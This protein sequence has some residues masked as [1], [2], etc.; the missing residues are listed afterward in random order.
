ENGPGGDW[1]VLVDVT[2]AGGNVTLTAYWPSPSGRYVAY[3]TAEGGSE[4]TT[5]RVQD[6]MTGKTLPDA[7]PY[8]GG[9]T[10]PQ[11]L[12]WDAD[13]R[14]VTY[15]RYPLPKQGEPVR[16]FDVALYP[17][18]LG[19]PAAEDP[20]VFGADYSPIAEYRLLSSGDGKA[21]AALVNKGD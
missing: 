2:E 18:V 7:L 3:G 4:L 14:G 19:P 8:A 10:S 12:V 20:V 5:I 17:H 1:R 13:E 21:A 11:A 15:A 16:L 9:G 6:V